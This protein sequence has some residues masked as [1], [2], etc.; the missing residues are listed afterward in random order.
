MSNSKRQKMSLRTSFVPVSKDGHFPIQNLPYGV[1]AK[2]DGVG[3][4]GV[5]I[6]DQI[7]DLSAVVNAGLLKGT[8]GGVGDGACFR[9]STLNTFMSMGKKAWSEARKIIGD[10]LDEQSTHKDQVTKALVSQS[11]VTMKLPCR[12]GDYTDFYSSR[13]HAYNVGVMFR[14]KDNALQPNW[15]HLPVGYHGRASSV[16]VSGTNLKRPN[17]QLVSKDKPTGPP[18]HGTCRLM[19]FECE[20]AC[21]VGTGNELGEPMNMDQAEASIFGLSTLNDWSARDIQKWEYIPL[22]PFGAKN[23]GSTVSP[24][25]IT[26]E[27]L[28]PFRITNQ[29]QEPEPL[30]YLKETSKRGLECYDINLEVTIKGEEMKEAERVSLTNA[31]YLY[32]NFKQQLVHHS[33][34]GCNMQPGDMLGSGTIS[35]P[36]P[37]EYGSMLELSWKGTKEVKVGDTAIRKFLKDGDEVNMNGWCQGDGFRVGF[38]PCSGTVLPANPL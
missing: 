5:A 33:V 25:I 27:A 13:Y 10:L 14:G 12:I 29:K 2:A 28:E 8:E 7:L 37:S 34:T 32:W 35:G 3:H 30:D 23:F 20:M 36:E 31:K 17:G 26:M 15:T 24:W 4:I 1:F 22:G 38:G 11:E 6:G 18:T 19:D 16:V 9:E 21:Y